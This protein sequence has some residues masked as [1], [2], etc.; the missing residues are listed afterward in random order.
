MK[1]PHCGKRII[2]KLVAKKTA[3]EK[4]KKRKPRENTLATK[5]EEFLKDYS[6]PAKVSKITDALQENGI[7]TKAKNFRAVVNRTLVID[8]RFKSVRR[9]YYSLARGRRSIS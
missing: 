7:K 4:R 5:I 2:V 1:C 9:G 3:G 8:K 6:R